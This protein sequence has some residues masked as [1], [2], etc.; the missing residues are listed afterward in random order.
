MFLFNIE[1]FFNIVNNI[2]VINLFDYKWRFLEKLI[3]CKN[4]ENVFKNF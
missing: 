1:V 4:I 2:L 3:Y